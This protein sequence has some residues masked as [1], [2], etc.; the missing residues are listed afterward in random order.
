[1]VCFGV[2]ERQ[3]V[4][5]TIQKNSGPQTIAVPP[6]K[7]FGSS[8][9][10]PPYSG[11]EWHA[12]IPAR[13]GSLSSVFIPAAASARKRRPGSPARRCKMQGRDG[14]YR[15]G[16]CQIF[17]YLR[18][19]QR[20]YEL[21]R[22]THHGAVKMHGESWTTTVTAVLERSSEQVIRHQLRLP[23][24]SMASAFPR[25]LPAGSTQGEFTC[26]LALINCI[27]P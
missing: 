10:P 16:G 24:L 22:C 7:G 6:P 15:N 25:L 23:A 2:F 27:R 9:L 12:S 4:R 1:M 3:F 20:F 26:R 11:A 8:V 21:R 18:S 19:L 13:R 17:R 5:M 14:H